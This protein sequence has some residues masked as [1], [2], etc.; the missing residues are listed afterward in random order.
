[1]QESGKDVTI[2]LDFETY[3]DRDYSLSKM[4]MIEYIMDDRFEVIGC[5]VKI[6]GTPTRW[7]VG[8]ARCAIIFAAIPWDRVNLVCHNAMFDA[9]ILKWR[10]DITPKQ[11]MCTM[12][13][14][15]PHIAP[16]TGG[17]MSLANVGSFIDP[18]MHK[19]AESVAALGMRLNDFNSERLSEYGEYCRNDVEMTATIHKE[20]LATLS[21]KEQRVIHLTIR[22]Y[23]E[24]QLMLDTEVIESA[25]AQ[26]AVR[27]QQVLARCGLD[28]KTLRSDAKFAGALRQLGVDPPTK[29]SP[30]TGKETY[31]FAK[32]DV[33][34]IELGD[35][36]DEDVAALVEARLA[37]KTTIE[38]SRLE[39]LRVISE[40]TGGWLPV[41]LLYYGAHTG[42]F[43]GY[44]KINL[45]N[46]PRGG[47]IRRAIIAPE[48]KLI[49][50]PDLSQIEARM[51]AWLANE[52]A[53]VNQFA[54]KDDVYA[55]FATRIYG[56][57]VNKKDYP[58]ERFVGKTGIL[59]LG[60]GM[61]AA[62]FESELER[63]GLDQSIAQDV[64]D[65]YRG[66][67]KKIRKLWYTAND[68]L[69]FMTSTGDYMSIKYKCL[70]IHRAKCPYVELPGGRR[71]YY[72]E[73]YEDGNGEFWYKGKRNKWTKIYGAKL[74]ENIVQALAQIVIMDAELRIDAA[75][76]K[77]GMTS[78]AAS[79][80]HDELLYIVPEKYAEKLKQV[81]IKLMVVPP[82][83]APEL[84]LDCEC[85]T[86][87]N[88]ADAK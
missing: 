8:E 76:N 37:V 36:E 47:S 69:K 7:V 55:N 68:W 70:T 9:S 58:D 21:E 52:W 86:G 50:A 77:I 74:I 42:R 59:G 15:R 48:G 57:E 88:Y 43:S 11:Y 14:A 44:D 73:L 65:V 29:I 67:F 33:G 20:L 79:Q 75:L 82:Q 18:T 35:S 12:M 34:F 25:Q 17:S 30:T 63:N 46:P 66:T 1:M 23:V 53:L 72:P 28:D 49:L 64:V 19:G 83:W 85:D 84:P 4:T 41:P 54:S 32:T 5:G 40:A 31:A 26:L 62:K 78:G 81:M 27:K 22:K 10:F 38:P 2:T 80:V 3:Y 6:N 45:Q 56:Y 87:H 39:R 24:P 13:G 51:L 60:Y 61:G 71:I 16:F